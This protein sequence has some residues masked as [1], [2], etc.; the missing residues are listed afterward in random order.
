MTWYAASLGPN[1]YETNTHSLHD[2]DKGVWKNCGPAVHSVHT[3]DV[4]CEYQH[5]CHSAACGG[6][7]M[8]PEEHSAQTQRSMLVCDG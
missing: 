4:R 2:R 5:P 6:R 8:D 7:Y 1:D 3:T